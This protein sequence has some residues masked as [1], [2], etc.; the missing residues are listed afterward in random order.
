MQIST[1]KLLKR[2]KLGSRNREVGSKINQLDAQAIGQQ[3]L[4]FVGIMR[5]GFPGHPCMIARTSGT[6]SCTTFR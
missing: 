1:K 2:I 3:A 4:A 5:V 6:D